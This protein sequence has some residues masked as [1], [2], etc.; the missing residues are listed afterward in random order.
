MTSSRI[1]DVSDIEALAWTTRTSGI[2]PSKFTDT[3]KMIAVAKRHRGFRYAIKTD[4]TL[5]KLKFL[6]DD[7]KDGRK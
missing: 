5:P 6:Q 1:L 3:K 7:D 4:V 2:D